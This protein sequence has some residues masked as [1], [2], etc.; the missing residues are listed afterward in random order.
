MAALCPKIFNLILPNVK[1]GRALLCLGKNN[2]FREYTKYLLPSYWA[3]RL[4]FLWKPF[5]FVSTSK[6]FLNQKHVTC[7]VHF[8]APQREN[9]PPSST[10]G[11][12]GG[13]GDKAF[14]KTQCGN[15]TEGRDPGLLSVLLS[16]SVSS[17]ISPNP[18]LII[19]S[20]KTFNE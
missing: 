1:A 19:Y 17:H 6:Y 8:W 16:Y 13:V 20:G 5:Q 10:L 3:N 4:N 12:G 2:P 15:N 18:S 14:H 11:G 7:L 9:P